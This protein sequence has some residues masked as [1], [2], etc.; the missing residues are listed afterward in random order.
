MC[1]LTKVD[2]D[3]LHALPRGQ[4]CGENERRPGGDLIKCAPALCAL[5]IKVDAGDLKVPGSLSEMGWTR[6]EISDPVLFGR[7][8]TV[9]LLP[10]SHFPHQ[11]R[12]VSGR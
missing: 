9:R 1:W 2:G 5:G 10:S 8:V 12:H 11:P 3:L 6:V 4:G 7:R